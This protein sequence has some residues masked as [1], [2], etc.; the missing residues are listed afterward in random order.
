M[1]EP[2]VLKACALAY[3]NFKDHIAVAASPKTPFEKFISDVN[4]Y[5]ITIIPSRDTIVVQFA[6][7]EFNGVRVRG[8]GYTYVLDS[9]GERILNLKLTR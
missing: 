5:N 8:G 9:A 1:E 7:Q 6:P 2:T 3:A 4:S